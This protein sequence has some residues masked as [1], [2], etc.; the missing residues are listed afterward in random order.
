MGKI[1]ILKEEVTDDEIYA[2]HIIEETESHRTGEIIGQNGN[3][4]AE[5]KD[6]SRPMW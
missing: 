5:D 2:S 3:L 4:L 6:F 1:V